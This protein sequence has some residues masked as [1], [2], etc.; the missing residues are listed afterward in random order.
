MNRTVKKG[1]IK[2]RQQHINNLSTVR[3]N[4]SISKCYQTKKIE[5][6]EVAIRYHEV[7]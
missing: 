6:L 5:L 4:S 3:E 1:Q 7:T 2:L